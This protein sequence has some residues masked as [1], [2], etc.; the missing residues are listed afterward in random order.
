MPKPKPEESEQ[1]FMTRCM[2]EV[3]ND[4]TASDEEQAFAV[5]KSLWNNKDVQEKVTITVDEEPQKEIQENEIKTFDLEVTIP[6]SGVF[7]FTTTEILNGFLEVLTIQTTNQ[8]D[9]K[10]CLEEYQNMSIYEVVSLVE[11]KYLPIR[12]P[13]FSESNEVYNF[14]QEK[15]AL[16]DRIYFL[17]RGMAGEQVQIQLRYC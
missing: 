3:I 17:I 8:I 10:I 2:P 15:W 1:D 12:L 5:C 7:E 9:I 11:N 13:A 4:G 6:E 16:N 14:S